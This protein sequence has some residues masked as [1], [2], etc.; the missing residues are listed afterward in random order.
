MV[1][2]NIVSGLTGG[3]GP[4]E[5]VLGQLSEAGI[6]ASALEGLDISAVTSLIADKGIDL[7][8]LEPLGISVEDIIAKITGQG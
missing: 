5:T 3:D 4:L 8:I 1:L 2:G 6:D 7:S